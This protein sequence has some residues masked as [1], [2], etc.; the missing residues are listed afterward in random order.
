MESLPDGQRIPLRK[1]KITRKKKIYDP[2]SVPNCKVLVEF[3]EKKD[4]DNS[5][6]TKGPQTIN[7]ATNTCK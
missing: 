3:L 5:T 7:M 2:E 1:I 4:C 6:E